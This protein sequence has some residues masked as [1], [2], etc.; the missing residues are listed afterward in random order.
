MGNNYYKQY[1][2]SN[3][4]SNEKCLYFG[5]D[6]LGNGFNRFVAEMD[7]VNFCITDENE[8]IKLKFL[9]EEAKSTVAY[10]QYIEGRKMRSYFNKN[11]HYFRFPITQQRFDVRAQM[12]QCLKMSGLECRIPGKF[13]D[14]RRYVIGV[15][16]LDD[17]YLEKLKQRH[18]Q[19]LVEANKLGFKFF[20]NMITNFSYYN[21]KEIMDNLKHNNYETVYKNGRFPYER[22]IKNVIFGKEFNNTEMFW[23]YQQ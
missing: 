18:E 13:E 8:L 9:F 6:W 15:D 22:E 3:K 20:E 16:L 5:I 23:S 1:Y 17:N 7:G 14:A 12:V 19:S 4:T 10:C 11:G 2:S 21:Q